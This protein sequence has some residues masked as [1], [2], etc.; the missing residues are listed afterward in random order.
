MIRT[1]VN[2]DVTLLQWSW[3]RSR[4]VGYSVYTYVVRGVLID[5]GFPGARDEFRAWLNTVTLRGA[6]VTHHHEDHAGNL[7]VVAAAGIPV[8]AHE[9]TLQYVVQRHRVPFYR[10]FAWSN[11]R[12]VTAALTPFVDDALHLVPTPGHSDDHHAVWDEDTGTLF[13]GD[14]Y[15]GGKVRIAQHGEDP[16]VLVS[17]LR[18]MAAR[19]PARVFCGHRGLLAHGAAQLLAKAEWMQE[20]IGEIDA[21]LAQGWTD[22]AI[23]REVLGSQPL[24]HWYSRG[25]YSP[26]TMIRLLRETRER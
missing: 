26:E 5:T 3:P 12:P 2:E 19:E 25:R 18:T 11:P 15:L 13:A 1:E 6:M 4:L 17:S 8:C 9:D 23:S 14:L 16:R 24:L 20:I 21:K 22:R 10:Q 7:D